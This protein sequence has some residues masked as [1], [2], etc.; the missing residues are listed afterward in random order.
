MVREPA[1]ALDHGTVKRRLEEARPALSYLS[2]TVRVI[3]SSSGFRL[4]ISLESCFGSMG[5]TV[6]GK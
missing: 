3:L 5:M 2:L 6:P 4:Q 1:G